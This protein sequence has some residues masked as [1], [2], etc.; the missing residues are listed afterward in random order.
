MAS[1]P[2]ASVAELA[3]ALGLD[4]FGDDETRAASL[5][6]RVSAKARR[7]ARRT[8]LDDSGALSSVPEVV[9]SIV[10]DSAIRTFS[11]TPGTYSETTGP[12][13]VMWDRAAQQGVFFTDDELRIL[14]SF[15]Q[16]S[17]PGLTSVKSSGLPVPDT[18]IYDVVAVVGT[19]GLSQAGLVSD[20]NPWAAW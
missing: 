9:W 8:W 18:I 6:A 5:L 3:D 15:R 7:E 14:R 19:D 4:D 1:V 12:T 16:G 17:R 20:G 10:I 11:A 2:L 13:A